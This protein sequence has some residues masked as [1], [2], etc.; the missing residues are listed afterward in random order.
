MSKPMR[1]VAIFVLGGCAALFTP[2]CGKEP[3][4][5]GT[6]RYDGACIADDLVGFIACSK[7]TGVDR[8]AVDQTEAEIKTEKKGSLPKVGV[9]FA[10]TILGVRTAMNEAR[11]T[12][13]MCTRILACAA[14][15]GVS[16][17]PCV[18]KGGSGDTFQTITLLPPAPLPLATP[19]GASAAS[20]GAP[21]AA[22]S[23]VTP[24]V[25]HARSDVVPREGHP[26]RKP[27]SPAKSASPSG[28]PSAPPSAPPSVMP[29]QKS[30]D[31]PG[32]TYR[33]AEG[34]CVDLDPCR[35]G[36]CWQRSPAPECRCAP[37]ASCPEGKKLDEST[38]MCVDRC[39]GYMR[40]CNQFDGCMKA[41][42][43]NGSACNGMKN[44]SQKDGC[45][46]DKPGCLPPPVEFSLRPAEVGRRVTPLTEVPLDRNVPLEASAS[47]AATLRDSRLSG[48]PDA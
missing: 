43:Q 44:Q 19:T 31:C 30:P 33:N 16:N 47:S 25:D 11:E 12:S 32:C 7:N 6:Q 20:G 3:C 18:V 24:A 35:D 17:V 14:K 5:S 45:W 29:S 42:S 9:E 21:P 39:Q 4:P 13:A 23:S 27:T 2:A 1:V 37:P 28:T 22:T 48:T 26:A 34:R 8:V 36:K 46:Q 38:C 41:T 15:A 40:N 10:A